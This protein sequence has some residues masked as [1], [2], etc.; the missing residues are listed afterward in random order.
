M[1]GLTVYIKE[2]LPFAQDVSLENSLDSYLCF[3]LALLHLASYFFFLSQSP[4]SLLCMLFDSVS[5]NIDE[6]LLINPSANV[7]LFGDFNVFHKDWLAYSGGTDRPVE[8]Y[9]SFS[10][11]NNLIQT[12]NFPTWTLNWISEMLH[13]RIF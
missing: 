13:G 10:I 6:V 7:F 9:Y 1:H 11:S 5:F 4:S 12:V 8:L 3:Q 2:G